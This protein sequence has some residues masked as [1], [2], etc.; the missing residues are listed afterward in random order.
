MRIASEAFRGRY[1]RVDVISST[2][3]RTISMLAWDG[4]ERLFTVQ[5]PRIQRH[6]RFAFQWARLFALVLRRGRYDLC[7]ATGIQSGLFA[8]VL[9]VTGLSRRT[10]YYA[11]DW[12][13][14]API[15][16]VLDLACCLAA[17]SVID[18]TPRISQARAARWP[19]LAG[20]INA[21]VVF[22]LLGPRPAERLTWPA[23]ESAICY[24]GG[25]RPEA[26]LELVVAAL[27]KLRGEGLRV[28]LHVTGA[29]GDHG[30]EQRFARY[31]QELRVVEQVHL[32][33]F[34]S[35][36]EMLNIL[37]RSVCGIC[38]TP[39]GS[40]NYSSFTVPRKVQ[41][42]MEAGLP[43]IV[44][45]GSYMADL[46][47]SQYAAVAAVDTVDS[48]AQAIRFMA[49]DSARARRYGEAAYCAALNYS[50]PQRFFDAQEKAA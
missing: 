24:I 26:G 37:C 25:V 11:S 5:L 6:L 27:V 9:R 18:P 41:D 35:D 38:L 4:V 42:Y 13:C 21:T 16:Q 36:A 46:L 40:A 43:S 28:H 22:P 15:L 29:V 2:G 44:S 50:D 32:H 31:V 39:G 47:G 3:A 1:E 30:Y 17:D 10:I 12:Y 23:K 49:D 20:R 19:K 14:A 34:V 45:A 8:A 33:G 48:V 7:V